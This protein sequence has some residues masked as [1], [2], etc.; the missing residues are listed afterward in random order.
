MR[1]TDPHVFSSRAT[2]QGTLAMTR[3]SRSLARGDVPAA[4]PLPG[5]PAARPRTAPTPARSGTSTTTGASAPSGIDRDAL[6]NYRFVVRR[7]PRPAPRRHPGR[8][9]PRTCALPALD[10]KP[11]PAGGPQARPSTSPCRWFN[12]SRTNVRRP[13]PGRRRPLLA[14]TRS[15]S[16][17]RTPASTR[18]RSSSAGSTSGCCST[19]RTRPASRSLPLARVEKSAEA[20][21]VPQLDAA[22]IPPVLACDAWDDLSQGDILQEVYD[23]IGRKIELLAAQVLSRGITFESHDPGRRP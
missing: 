5:G 23:R 11:P 18:S 14:S 2:S 19:A 1:R 17:T 8:P 13:R 16:R 6:A 21:A 4:A 9:S 3:A 22:Y 10:L 7:A 12:P 20:D 15:A